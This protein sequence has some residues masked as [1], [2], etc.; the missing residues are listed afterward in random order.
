MTLSSKSSGY[1]LIE[2][3]AVMTIIAIITGIGVS[4]K[5]DS[6]QTFTNDVFQISN[7]IEMTQNYSQTK[8]KWTRIL[9]SSTI[10]SLTILPLVLA[11]DQPPS[12]EVLM[13][14]ENTSAWVPISKAISFN[15]IVQ[16]QSSD[17]ESNNTKSLRE[18]KIPPTLRKCGSQDKTFQ[19][20]MQFNPI[21][22]LLLNDFSTSFKKLSWSIE[23]TKKPQQK[24][25]IFIDGLSGHVRI[26]RLP[27]SETRK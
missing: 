24:A 25:V 23:S 5:G 15:G 19:F 17:I 1:T 21:G 6:T 2:M 12:E 27:S 20:S 11:N 9:I 22:E 13:Q 18:F 3:M 26:E 10:T 7:Q 14:V 8:R 16:S 4:F